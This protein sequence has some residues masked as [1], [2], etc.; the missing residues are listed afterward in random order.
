MKDRGWLRAFRALFSGWLMLSTTMAAELEKKVVDGVNYQILR[1]SPEKVRILWRDDADQP[2]RT[3]PAAAAFLAKKGLEPAFLMN[4][5]IFEPGGIPSGLLVQEGETVRPV[6]RR[7]GRG[8]FFLKP[9]GILLIGKNGARVIR[10]DEYPLDGF[11]VREAVQ[12][13]PLLLRKGE[14]HPA[15]NAGSP[16]RLHRNGV[17][18]DA[19][20]RL[21]FAITEFRS[22]KM[23]NLHAFAMLFK[24]LGCE[25]ALFLDGDISQLRA[26]DKLDRPSNRF[27]SIFVIFP[28]SESS[29]DR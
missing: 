11:E 21:V 23:P 29:T 16:N 15:F 10:T 4:G 6:N 1:T 17:G 22:P 20:G 9:N 5:G 8:N 12:S 27:G 28:E 25:D 24:S 7:D 19:E 3:F 18:V 13:G 2:L 26:T 14:P